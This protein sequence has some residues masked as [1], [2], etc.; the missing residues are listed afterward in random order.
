MQRYSLHYTRRKMRLAHGNSLLND[1]RL[2]ETDCA[3]FLGV[4]TLEF[5]VSQG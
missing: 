2:W 3:S 1:A 5:E 4:G